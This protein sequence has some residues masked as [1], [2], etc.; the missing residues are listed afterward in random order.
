MNNTDN[1][2]DTRLM[3]CIDSHDL[4]DE[5]C[6]DFAKVLLQNREQKNYQVRVY[7]HVHND[8]KV[9]L[10]KKLGKA[11]GMDLPEKNERS[12]ALKDRATIV[13]DTLEGTTYI[14]GSNQT[15]IQSYSSYVTDY[16]PHTL[17][18]NERKEMLSIAESIT[19]VKELQ[20]PTVVITR[21]RVKSD[22]I[23]YIVCIAHPFDERGIKA[24]GVLSSFIRVVD[25]VIFFSCWDPPDVATAMYADESKWISE[26]KKCETQALAACKK[27]SELLG[28]LR[29]DLDRGTFKVKLVNN[30]TSTGISNLV[31]NMSPDKNYVNV[32]VGSTHSRGASRKKSILNV[33]KRRLFGTTADAILS[34]RA[35]PAVTVVFR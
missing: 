14:D 18:A 8:S 6:V 34:N 31:S 26:T 27:G 35:I 23:T 25:N 22:S 5:G 12:Q 9:P 28:N 19:L 1:G 32:V 11:L 24:I 30:S 29:P 7:G 13:A 16:K 2:T 3:V 20:A 10:A 4:E 15:M 21:S 33:A 17:I